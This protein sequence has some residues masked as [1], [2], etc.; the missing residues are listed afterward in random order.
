MRSLIPSTQTQRRCNPCESGD[1]NCSLLDPRLREPL[2]LFHEPADLKEA[3]GGSLH[4]SKH[5]VLTPRENS[6]QAAACL[7][8]HP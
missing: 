2:Q 3:L 4:H 7:P 1:Q 8:D 5:G 6:R